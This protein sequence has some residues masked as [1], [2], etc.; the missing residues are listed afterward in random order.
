MVVLEQMANV[1]KNLA[2][3]S[4]EVILNRMD[5][6]PP[7]VRTQ[8]AFATYCPKKKVAVLRSAAAVPSFLNAAPVRDIFLSMNTCVKN[9][10]TAWFNAYLNA[11]V[12][13]PNRANVPLLDD[14]DNWV[15]AVIANTPTFL[16]NQVQALISLYNPTGAAGT[17]LDVD[18]SWAVLLDQNTNAAG[19]PLQI[20][21]PNSQY[22]TGVPVSRNDLTAQVLNAIQDINWLNQLPIH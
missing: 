9:A 16:R 18:L 4:T 11:N 12:D 5:Q 8:R 17:T 15:H 20:P 13:A 21:T 6:A 10:W 3:T 19:Q 1:I 7:S 14:Y 22:A 2:F